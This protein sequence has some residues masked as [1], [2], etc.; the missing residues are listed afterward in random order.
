MG[1]VNGPSAGVADDEFGTER[2]GD[3][4]AF[5]DRRREDADLTAKDVVCEIDHRI[6]DQLTAFDQFSTSY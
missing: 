1:D 5:G 2:F 4:A 3:G 6:D